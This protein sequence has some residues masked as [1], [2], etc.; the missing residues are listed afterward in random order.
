MML[1]IKGEKLS[2]IGPCVKQK[3][4]SRSNNNLI[5]SDATFGNKNCHP[6]IAITSNEYFYTSVGKHSSTL[7]CRIILQIQNALFFD[8]QFLSSQLEVL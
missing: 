5:T 7:L 1:F 2:K 8:D 4:P 6:P 3:F